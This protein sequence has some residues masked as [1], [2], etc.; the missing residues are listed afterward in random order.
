MKLYKYFS[1]NGNNISALIN[2]QIWASKASSF[3]D[4]F[5]TPVKWLKFSP[6]ITAYYSGKN[7]D[8]TLKDFVRSEPTMPI[9]YSEEEINEIESMG[10]I[11]FSIDNSNMLIWSHYADQHQG[12]ALEFDIPDD[13]IEKGKNPKLIKVD[14]DWSEIKIGPMNRFVEAARYKDSVWKY[15]N[16]IRLIVPEGNRLYDWSELNR[17]GI[18][19]LSGIIFGSRISNSMEMALKKICDSLYPDINYMKAELSNEAF[20]FDICPIQYQS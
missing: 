19:G 13:A 20:K 7:E 9:P 2:G 17:G 16:E 12:Y 6:G 4:P 15:E 10:I 5:D 18:N 14:Y 11:C 8:G 3:N 1:A